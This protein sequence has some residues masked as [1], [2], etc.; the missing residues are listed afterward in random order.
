VTGYALALQCRIFNDD[1]GLMNEPSQSVPF[2]ERI[3]RIS[4]AL[5]FHLEDG[6]SACA[7]A[8]TDENR[9]TPTARKT[10]DP[11]RFI[12]ISRPTLKY[13][14]GNLEPGVVQGNFGR[15]GQR[16]LACPGRRETRHTA[17]PAVSFNN[18]KELCPETIAKTLP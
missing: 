5:L 11:F 4:L 1:F 13:S 14:E 10:R 2:T 3:S 8:A 17:S 15:F 12:L 6:V 7:H 9:K 18:H 16:G